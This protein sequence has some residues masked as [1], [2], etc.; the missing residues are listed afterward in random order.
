MGDLGDHRSDF[1]IMGDLGDHRS[2]F[3]IMGD[4]GDHRSDFKIMVEGWDNQELSVSK[5]GHSGFDPLHGDEWTSS[6]FFNQPRLQPIGR[7]ESNLEGS[8]IINVA[9]PRIEPGASLTYCR[10][11]QELDPFLGVENSCGI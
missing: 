7:F 6:L 5:F 11:N 1:K 4:L 3:K 9:N 10:A 8:L 2:D